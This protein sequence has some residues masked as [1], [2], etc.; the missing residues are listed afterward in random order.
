MGQL[1]TFSIR[2]DDR[3]SGGAVLTALR[4]YPEF[5][6]RVER[7][8]VGDYLVEERLLF[9]RKTLPDLVASIKDGRLFAQGERLAK[10]VPRGALILE[11]TTSDLG[12]TRMSREAIQGALVSLALFYDLPLLRASDPAETARLML[13][14]ARQARAFARGTIPRH[15]RRPRGKTR[16]QSHILQGLPRVGPERAKRLIDHFGSVQ[17]VIAADAEALMQVPGIG[18]GVAEVIRWAVRDEPAPDPQRGPLPLA[19]ESERADPDPCAPLGRDQVGGWTR[20]PRKVASPSLACI[21][22]SQPG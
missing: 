16:L 6:I 4:G 17:A 2:V 13:F 7:L 14:A 9:E 19:R 8:A 3:E 15:G 10:A 11:G 5:D 12:A 1:Q 20:D 21:P 22:A 18:A